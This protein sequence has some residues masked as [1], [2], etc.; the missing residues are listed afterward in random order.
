HEVHLFQRLLRGERRRQVRYAGRMQSRK[1]R[2]R[3]KGKEKKEVSRYA[4]L[5]LEIERAAAVQRPVYF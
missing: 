1:G 4:K 3:E 2:Q 5:H